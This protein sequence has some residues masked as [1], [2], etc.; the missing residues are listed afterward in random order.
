[1]QDYLSIAL[2]DEDITNELFTDDGDPEMREMQLELWQGVRRDLLNDL[3]SVRRE[4]LAGNL[5]EARRLAHR[6]AGY[7]GSGGLKRVG[8]VLRKLQHAEIPE[9]QFLPTLD[10][11]AVWGRE[12]MEEIE[13][14]FPYLRSS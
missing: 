7:S 4:F 1:M 3:E 8:A 5:D 6:V 11:I 10:E 2:V 14:R 12:G 9:E 13:T